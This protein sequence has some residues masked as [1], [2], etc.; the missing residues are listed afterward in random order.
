MPDVVRCAKKS[1]PEINRWRRHKKL[2][3]A[4]CKLQIEET[5]KNRLA[6]SIC[7]MQF[8][9]CNS[10]DGSD[11]TKKELGHGYIRVQSA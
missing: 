1:V 4:D 7:N 11:P 3:I 8:E 6:S 9:I 5:A 10:A 2:K